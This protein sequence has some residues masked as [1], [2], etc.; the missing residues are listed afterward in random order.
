MVNIF[1][2][3][4]CWYSKS[5]TPLFVNSLKFTEEVKVVSMG[6]KQVTVRRDLRLKF[7]LINVPFHKYQKL[8]IKQH[9][10]LSAC[11]TRQ[12]ISMEVPLLNLVILK[13]I[14]CCGTGTMSITILKLCLI[15]AVPPPPFFNTNS[16]NI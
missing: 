7:H 11:R 13:Q 6:V 14:N 8:K 5:H 15:T 12:V 4:I 16:R 9:L 3:R 1:K 2:N 10:F